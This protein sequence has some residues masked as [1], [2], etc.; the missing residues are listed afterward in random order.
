MRERARLVVATDRDPSIPRRPLH[1]VIPGALVALAALTAAI[2]VVWRTWWTESIP[3]PTAGWLLV[4]CGSIFIVATFLFSYGW[5]LYDVK[6]A[7][8]LTL[9]LVFFG[10]AIV[11]ILALV[12]IALKEADVDVGGGGAGDDGERDGGWLRGL[13][14]SRDAGQDGPV[15]GYPTCPSCAYPVLPTS[16][17][18]C[19]RCGWPKRPGDRPAN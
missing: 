14:G 4:I 15:S 19:P 17:Y 2:V 18:P 9:L 7:V 3:V 5:R 10:V 16:E 11:A 12:L 8:L 13:S 6:G 1:L